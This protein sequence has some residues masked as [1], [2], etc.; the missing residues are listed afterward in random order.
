MEVTFRDGY[1]SQHVI[2]TSGDGLQ[3]CCQDSWSSCEEVLA[4]A[5]DSLAAGQF[6]L[7]S[8]LLQ[9]AL[10]EPQA[11]GKQIESKN[12]NGLLEQKRRVKFSIHPHSL[13]IAILRVQSTLWRLCKAGQAQFEV[14]AKISR[15]AAAKNIE[16]SGNASK[17][18]ALLVDR[19]EKSPKVNK[20]SMIRK[21]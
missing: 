14:V 1:G 17:G 19:A 12:M 11:L 2:E 15:W 20:R 6:L 3:W 8:G 18:V 5:V 9:A 13:P 4:I 7:R 21:M 10:T 16:L